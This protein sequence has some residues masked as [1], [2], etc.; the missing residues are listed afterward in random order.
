M[1]AKLFFVLIV[2][3]L[4]KVSAQDKPAQTLRGSIIDKSIKAHLAG[5]TVE[6]TGG[7]NKQTIANNDGVFKFEFIPVGR[8]TI[9]I[10][11]IGYK[12]I[13]IPNIALE[14]GKET[15]L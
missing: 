14:S 8:Y 7:I 2:L 5:A 3:I 6:L 10:S 9:R 12:S 4:S 1:K 15:Y 11:Y 13:T